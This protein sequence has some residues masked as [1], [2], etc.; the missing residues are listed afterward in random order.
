MPDPTP[1]LHV[2]L[3]PLLAAAAPPEHPSASAPGVGA[4]TPPG[5]AIG[6][7]SQ[8][9]VGGS[10]S[11]EEGAGGS[12]V[13]ASEERAIRAHVWDPSRPMP[14][15]T[16]PLQVTLPPL[17]AAAAPP[18][19]PSASARGMEPDTRAVGASWQT[20]QRIVGGS[21]S[22]EEGAGGSGVE[23]SEAVPLLTGSAG[24]LAPGLRRRQGRG[25]S[26]ADEAKANP[27]GPDVKSPETELVIVGSNL[28]T[29][30][31]SC[32]ATHHLQGTDGAPYVTV[33]LFYRPDTKLMDVHVNNMMKP[34]GSKD[35]V[36]TAYLATSVFK[37]DKAALEPAL[38]DI[39]A[40][41]AANRKKDN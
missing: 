9:I 39:A 32:L 13:E 10:S 5:D 8:R 22:A 24:Q 31:A 33:N 7:R 28:T 34:D 11:T 6:Q 21:S 37:K 23:G 41:H 17:L 40:W 25:G 19:H 18:E 36:N 1:P 12:G 4:E 2:T 16:P 29:A 3:S 20:D 38:K 35:D 14:D 26:G 27:G 30:D 15:P